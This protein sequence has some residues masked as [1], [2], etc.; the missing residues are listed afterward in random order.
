MSQKINDVRDRLIVA[1]DVPTVWDAYHLVSTLGDGVTFYK[2]GY[3][4]AFAGGLDLARQLVA[5]GKKVFLDLKLHDIGNTVTEGV[6]SLTK[7]GVTFLTV[8]AYPQTM[9]GAVEG[10]GDAALKLLA[11]TALTSY[12][13]TDLRDAGYG[14]AVRDLVRLRAEQARSAG[15]DGIVCSA[16]ETAIGPD[17]V[18][19]NPGIRPSGSAAGDQKR[20]LTPAEAIRIGADHLVVGRPIIRAADPRAAAGAVMDEIVAAS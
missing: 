1:L 9:R 4:L 19:V 15:I 12:D 2:I 3:R 18:I 8:H 17:I 16:A 7:L 20:T 10:R 14:L 11:V 5:E 13:D 6:E